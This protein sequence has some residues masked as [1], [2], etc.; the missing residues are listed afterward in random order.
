MF[1]L[2]LDDGPMNNMP[3]GEAL[4]DLSGSGPDTLAKKA[5]LPV[6]VIKRAEFSLGEPIITTT[7]LDA[8][9]RALKAAGIV[10]TVDEPGVRLENEGH[11]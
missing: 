3:M 5:R 6:R 1:V 2:I 10:L 11:L 9:L 4:S 7:Q 8:L